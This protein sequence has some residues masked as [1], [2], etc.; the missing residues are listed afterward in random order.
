MVCDSGWTIIITKSDCQS[1][2]KFASNNVP[3]RPLT[4]TASNWQ[5]QKVQNQWLQF[6]PQSPNVNA[7]CFKD[8]V[9]RNSFPQL[10]TAGPQA[11]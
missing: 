8:T 3:C 1:A 7:K 6:K 11:S 4:P 5:E 9:G 10:L 2:S